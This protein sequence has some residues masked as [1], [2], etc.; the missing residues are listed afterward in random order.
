MK[1]QASHIDG[2]APLRVG[3]AGRRPLVVNI[4]VF[5]SKPPTLGHG[6]RL[7]SSGVRRTLLLSEAYL[8]NTAEEDAGWNLG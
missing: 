5:R 7:I 4:K 6:R 8:E 1:K 2:C 3:E